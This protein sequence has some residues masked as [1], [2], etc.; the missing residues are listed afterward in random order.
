MQVNTGPADS[1][2]GRL[3]STG[4]GAFG[5]LPPGEPLEAASASL[6]TSQVASRAKTPD[7][8]TPHGPQGTSRALPGQQLPPQLPFATETTKVNAVLDQATTTQQTPHKGTGLQFLAWE[9]P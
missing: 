4:S 5:D 6:P 8:A 7:M 1:T 9:G 3:R 2:Q